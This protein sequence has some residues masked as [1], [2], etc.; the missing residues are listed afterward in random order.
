MRLSRVLKAAGKCCQAL[1]TSPVA[2]LKQLSHVPA[3]VHAAN[4]ARDWTKSLDETGKTEDDLAI[5]NNPLRKYFEGVNE[6]PGIWKWLHYFNVYHQHL[7][8]FV[9]QEV[10]MVEVGVYSG[11]SMPMWREYFG[12]QCHVHGVD[13]EDACKIYEN[14]YTTIHIGDQ[15]DRQ[16]WKKFRQQVP[17]VDILI[18]DG[19]HKPHQQIV[20]LEEI[21]PHLRP[22]GIFI[23]EDIDG[24]GNEFTS[25]VNALNHS[26]NAMVRTAD[27]QNTVCTRTNFQSEIRSITVYPYMVVI[28]KADVPTPT[29]TAP[30]HGTKWQPF[31]G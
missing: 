23:C 8:K 13:I 6:G 16:F 4:Y 21:L 20:T 27:K 30:K 7:Q 28:E 11:G 17:Q 2:S 14:D 31:L 26:L 3:Q 1:A 19:G 5:E 10:S 9:G 24:I 25:Y 18:D 22:G 29:L 12:D 15:A